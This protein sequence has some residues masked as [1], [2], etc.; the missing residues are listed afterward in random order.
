MDVSS[1][2][3]GAAVRPGAWD[4]RINDFIA[5]AIVAC[6]LMEFCSEILGIRDNVAIV[7][8]CLACVSDPLMW[9]LQDRRRE[10]DLP[11]RRGTEVSAM[12]ASAPWLVLGWLHAAHPLWPVW[13]SVAVP[14]VVRYAGLA[15]ALGVVLVRPLVARIPL[16]SDGE[17]YVP[18][19]T[20][21]SQLLMISV[22]LVSCSAIAA[23]LTLYWLAA[24][25]IQ[26]LVRRRVSVIS[27]L[28]YE[29]RQ[30]SQI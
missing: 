3:G 2:R 10:H 30:V 9:L 19:L 24:A 8:L 27:A 29:V 6:V 26:Q 18:R 15:I 20:L 22:L 5:L 28:P 7:V 16:D 13:Q 4:R 12:I 14:T 21:E 1:L 23:C 25:G 17:A 11:A